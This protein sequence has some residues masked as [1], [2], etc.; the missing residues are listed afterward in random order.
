M[1]A[2]DKHKNSMFSLL[3]SDPDTLRELYSAIEGVELPADVPID[4]NTLSNALFMGQINDVSFTVGGRLIV[5]IEHQST[6]NQ[7]MPLRLLMYAARLYEKIID[8]MKL[9]QTGLEK[10]PEPV[11][12]VLYNGKAPYPERAT[13]KLSDAFKDASGLRV[14]T[15]GGT[16]PALELTVQ[17]YNINQ[18]CNAAML[19]KCEALGGYSVFVSKVWEY[20]QT[21]TLEDAMKA[22][23]RYC[24]E[25]GILKLFLETHSSEVQNMLIT[26][27]NLEEAQ[28]AWL[29]QGRDE[30]RSEGRTEGRNEGRNEGKEQARKEMLNFIA[31]GY[32]LEDI[33]R[34][35]SA[36]ARGQ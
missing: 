20:R 15:P 33:Q 19:E 21:M 12:I 35:L 7:N 16:S 27:W 3:F 26:E 36:A 32:T 34:E 29:A 5:L 8:R 24:I 2:N 1:G 13:L 22:A 18:G 30:G 11:F 23:I 28:Q 25:N 9:Y 14:K 31:K 6:I 4:V 17:V 10:I